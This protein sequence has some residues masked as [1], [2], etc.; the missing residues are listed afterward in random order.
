MS[1]FLKADQIPPPPD[2]E[3]YRIFTPLGEL[4]VWFLEDCGKV[5]KGD[6][7][8]LEYFNAHALTQTGL[9]GRSLRLESMEPIELEDFFQGSEAGILVVPPFDALWD[10]VREPSEP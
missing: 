7:V 9:C 6:P 8:A 5:I 10:K 4:L 2:K 1:E 3:A